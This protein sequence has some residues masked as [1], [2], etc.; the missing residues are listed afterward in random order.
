MGEI[1][2][3]RID[4]PQGFEKLCV[5]KKILPHLLE[6]KDFV[7][8]FGNE[9]RTLVKLTHGSIAQ[10]LDM[11][12]HNGE[13]YL[14]LEYI[15]GKDLRKVG[16]RF[17][18]RGMPLPMTFVL[19]VMGRVLDALA[20]AHRKRDDD[21]KEIGLVHR[22]MSPQNIL[23]SYEGEVKVIDFGLAKSTLNASKTN[24][25]IILG[26][27]LYM[28]PEQ[29]RHAKV[30]KRSD[31]YAVGICLYE[32]IAG[33][34]PFEDIPPHALMA[35]VATPNIAHV[36]TIEPLCPSN[37]AAII[38]KALAVDPAQRFQTAEELRGK[39]LGALL[40]I[41]PA[42]GPESCS[43]FMRDMFAAEY[44][45]ER[46]L[47]SSLKE[48]ARAEARPEV[49]E[50]GTSRPPAQVRPLSVAR[51]SSPRLEPPPEDESTP[52]P[53][54]L[55]QYGME[56]THPGNRPLETSPLSFAPTPRIS[57]IQTD[58]SNEGDRETMPGVIVHRPTGADD[59]RE[60]GPHD[61]LH[62]APAAE[63]SESAP[64]RPVP[65]AQPR[66]VS[67]PVTSEAPVVVAP[68]EDLPSVMVSGLSSQSLA[69][70]PPAA[71][72]QSGAKAPVVR[73]PVLMP[74]AAVRAPEVMAPLPKALEGKHRPDD[75]LV[76]DRGT[77]AKR[78]SMAVVLVPLLAFLAL[79]SFVGYSIWK[80]QYETELD[81]EPSGGGGMKVKALK[82]R[83]EFDDDIAVDPAAAVKVE[84][85][86]APLPAPAPAPAPEAVVE[87][88]LPDKLP[89]P[90]PPPAAKGKPL[91]KTR[92]G[93]ELARVRVLFDKAERSHVLEEK[94]ENALR[95]KLEVL[96]HRVYELKPA[97]EAKFLSELQELRVTLEKAR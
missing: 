70:P 14:A 4:G 87:D 62:R 20:Y 65:V 97:Q 40:E 94:Q 1:F 28:S 92:A 38:M 55:R 16:A 47:L 61:A 63:M 53:T 54:D 43:R 24:P 10:V 12:Q 6:D 80:E 57:G 31:L 68:D 15:D 95:L 41:D 91:P 76:T 27:F 30:D 93:K 71:R 21:D 86:P 34:N 25:S 42:A 67:E 74:A 13:P 8:R 75:N 22:D 83:P 64:T 39:L 72:P 89:A 44:G 81:D 35:A 58:K 85:V 11:G 59:D 3:A 66:P 45:A 17:R 2:L 60:T 77:K 56:E 49:T 96:E 69:P 37:I 50:P 78:T 32:L 84:P 90:A 88:A 5:I 23:I 51:A 73:A 48:A 33:K 82:D 18:E 9:A 7:S 29:A 26:K 36:Q 46:K 79:A 19:F 52:S